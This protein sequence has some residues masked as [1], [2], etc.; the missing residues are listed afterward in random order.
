MLRGHQPTPPSDFHPRIP[1]LPVPEAHDPRLGHHLI[2]CRGNKAMTFVGF[3]VG[4]HVG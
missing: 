1:G 4:F 2:N 3:L